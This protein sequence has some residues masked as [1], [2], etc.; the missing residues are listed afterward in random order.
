MESIT[1]MALSVLLSGVL[2]NWLVNRW[3]HRNWINQQRLTKAVNDLQELKRLSETIRALADARNYRARKVCRSIGIVSPEDLKELR[4]QHDLAVTNWND[5]WNY[6]SVGLTIYAD[7]IAFSKR[8]EDGIQSRFVR[9]GGLLK[10]CLDRQSD[11]SLPS[12][13]KELE[14]VLNSISGEVFNFSRDL[15]NLIRAKEKL[16]YEDPK[17]NVTADN[18]DQISTLGLIKALFKAN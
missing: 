3:Q 15:Q 5:Q 9:A 6:F 17:E 11:Q 18:L 7:F 16:A 4:Q 8:L 2:V 1:T 10:Y 14:G 13:K 12:A